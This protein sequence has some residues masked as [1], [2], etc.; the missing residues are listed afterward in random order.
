M[1]ERPWVYA[2]L[3]KINKR[4]GDEKFPLITQYYYPNADE[5]IITPDYPIVV[6]LGHA[7]AGVS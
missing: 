6:K 3:V 7:H 5:M 2:E 4:L 1:M